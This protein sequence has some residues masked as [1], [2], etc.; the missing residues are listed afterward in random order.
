MMNIG[1]LVFHLCCNLLSL[2]L[3]FPVKFL[4]DHIERISNQLFDN[5]EKVCGRFVK[6]FFLWQLQ[7]SYV[8]V[9]TASIA[10]RILGCGL[11]RANKASKTGGVYG[12]GRDFH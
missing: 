5:L 1:K 7:E 8:V 11:L 4:L 12:Q 6:L 2:L 3:D 10:Y 9:A